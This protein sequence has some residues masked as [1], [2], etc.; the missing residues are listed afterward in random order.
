MILVFL[1][2]GKEK[3]KLV[4]GFSAPLGTFATRISAAFAM[5]LIYDFEFR[6]CERLRKVRNYFAHTIDASFKDEK[7]IV[8]CNQL[9]FAAQD[10]K[11]VVVD[12]RGKYTSSS[13]SIILSFTARAVYVSRDPLKLKIWDK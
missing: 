9:E 6:E 4:E 8:I 13:L 5:G 11:D 2:D 7:I 3:Q 10:F 12:G 1:L